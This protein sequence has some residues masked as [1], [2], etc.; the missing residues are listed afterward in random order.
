MSTKKVLILV[1]GK[2]TEPAIVG[3][4]KVGSAGC[5]DFFQLN[6]YET[7]VY[8]TSIYEIVDKIKEVGA[9]NFDLVAYLVAEKGLIIS[10]QIIGPPR[11]AFSSVYLIFDYDPHYQKFSQ[12]SIRFL[13]KFFNNETTNG[14]LYINYPMVE[15]FFH[16]TK[17]HNYLKQMVSTNTKTLSSYKQL[18]NDETIFKRRNN[19]TNADLKKIIVNNYNKAKTITRARGSYIKQSRLLMSQQIKQILCKKIFVLSSIPLLY[20][21]YNFDLVL[22]KYDIKR[23]AGGMLFP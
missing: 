10:P 1:E 17:N 13:A 16:I 18:V 7:V 2:K 9:D 12:K 19:L 4:G 21:D 6:N 5:F 11:N 23:G 3:T 20:L 22:K 15:S 14:K 8:E